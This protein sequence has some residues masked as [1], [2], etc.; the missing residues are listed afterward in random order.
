MAVVK[1]LSYSND[2]S[3]GH[4]LVLAFLRGDKKN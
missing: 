3:F 1:L 4:I 2:L